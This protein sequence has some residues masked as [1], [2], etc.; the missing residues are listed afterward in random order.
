M[1][2]E[3][4]QK[5][6]P[7]PTE[8]A[9]LALADTAAE[10]LEDENLK[11]ARR[12]LLRLLWKDTHRGVGSGDCWHRFLH[13]YYPDNGAGTTSAPCVWLEHKRDSESIKKY[14]G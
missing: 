10:R 7:T 13:Q 6:G 9:Y 2:E 8:E 12:K 1:A 5:A 3:L 11:N 4:R 14:E